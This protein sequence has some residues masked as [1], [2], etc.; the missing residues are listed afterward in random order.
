V[1]HL[2]SLYWQPG[3]I[4]S[5]KADWQELVESLVSQDRW[6]MDGNYGGT[7]EM[8]LQAS[9]PFP[10]WISLDVSASFAPSNAPWL[11]ND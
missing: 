8:R 11:T 4:E 9:I 6:I 7:L 10:S 3:W 1:I 2:D 5:P